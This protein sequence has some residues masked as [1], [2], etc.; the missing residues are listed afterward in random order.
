MHEH[1][2]KLMVLTRC[3]YVGGL[4]ALH[5]QLIE[6]VSHYCEKLCATAKE[7]NDSR[8]AVVIVAYTITLT[9]FLITTLGCN[10][11]WFITF[12]DGSRKFKAIPETMQEYHMKL[13]QCPLV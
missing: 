5:T 1:A 12:P 6:G 8:D 10:Y 11:I 4:S 2:T 13:P 3:S 7:W 9:Y